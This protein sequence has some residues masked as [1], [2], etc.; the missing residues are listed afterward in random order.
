MFRKYCI[1]LVSAL[2]FAGLASAA[3]AGS[4]FEDA[5]ANGGKKLTG[6][7]LAE[8]LKGKTVTFVS[9]ATGDKYLVFY[10][11]TNEAAS[12]K[13]GGSGSTSGFHAITDRDQVCLGWEGRDL[14]KLRCMDVVLID[15]VMHKYKADGSL[16]GQISE[17]VDGNAV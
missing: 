6:P 3:Q 10:G 17:V 14:P 7:E 16:S 8:R 11:E 15:G 9:S 1:G 12:R 4:D 13:V 5:L 2:A